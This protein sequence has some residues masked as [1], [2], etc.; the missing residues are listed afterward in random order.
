MAQTPYNRPYDQCRSDG[1]FPRSSPERRTHH[2]SLQMRNA[3]GHPGP[4]YTFAVLRLEE[5][6]ACD[7][8][9]WLE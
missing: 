8:P 9:N 5:T 6:E 7:V 4:L 3:E 1:H 2:I